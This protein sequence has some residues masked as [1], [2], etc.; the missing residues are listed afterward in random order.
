MNEEKLPRKMLVFSV[1]NLLSNVEFI[2][3]VFCTRVR[4]RTRTHIHTH[5]YK[6]LGVLNWYCSWIVDWTTKESGFDSQ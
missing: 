5:T 2:I 4:T 1:V 3:V 6:L